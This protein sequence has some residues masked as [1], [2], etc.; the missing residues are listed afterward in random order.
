METKISLGAARNGMHEQIE[1]DGQLV[2]QEIYCYAEL[3]ALDIM[4]RCGI[5]SFQLPGG[6][7]P[8]EAGNKIIEW[9][10][11]IKAQRAVLAMNKR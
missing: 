6:M 9:A 7:T 2:Q 11:Q 5:A 3:H 4:C 1:V 10:E 8:H